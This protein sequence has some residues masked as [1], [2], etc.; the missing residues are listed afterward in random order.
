MYTNQKLF[1]CPCLYSFLAKCICST[2]FD[3][4]VFSALGDGSIPELTFSTSLKKRTSL[5][6]L[7]SL[8]RLMIRTNMRIRT[9]LLALEPEVEVSLW[10]CNSCHNK[11]TQIQIH[12]LI[13]LSYIRLELLY[14]SVMLEQL[15]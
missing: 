10:D 12:I 3:F 15:E 9:I 14:N 6:T 13:P 11:N 7:R 5:E 4:V 2:R 8:T 1:S